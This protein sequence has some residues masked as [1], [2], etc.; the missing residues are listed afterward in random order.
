MVSVFTVLGFV[1]AAA[2]LGEIS[3]NMFMFSC[4]TIL[5]FVV[6]Q[7]NCRK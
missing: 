1:S 2:M 5:G 7:M 6:F 3:M 4:V